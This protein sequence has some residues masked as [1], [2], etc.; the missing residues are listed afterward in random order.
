[1][2]G[3]LIDRLARLPGKP[4]IEPQASSSTRVAV[5]IIYLI[6]YHAMPAS[7]GYEPL[8]VTSSRDY[9]AF[10]WQSSVMVTML[11]MRS[12]VA[13][14]FAM[15]LLFVTKN[16]RGLSICSQT[17]GSGV[18]LKGATL[19]QATSDDESTFSFNSLA[20]FFQRMPSSS[21]SLTMP[22][23]SSS[24][25]HANPSRLFANG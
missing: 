23:S 2:A 12:D 17:G 22:L 21:S 19:A 11:S 18:H 16:A 20:A 1:M 25:S 10:K 13:L 15:K 7:I 4:V 3:R 9:G 6:L 24:S 5:L 14:A 8:V